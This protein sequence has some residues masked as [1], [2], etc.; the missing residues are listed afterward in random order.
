[1]SES[2]ESVFRTVTKHSDAAV[3]LDKDDGDPQVAHCEQDAG[4]R[5]ALKW[6][7]E[8]S[9]DGRVKSLAVVALRPFNTHGARWYA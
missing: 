1:M 4:A 8:N 6:I 5:A 9:T 7:A 2:Y 3:N